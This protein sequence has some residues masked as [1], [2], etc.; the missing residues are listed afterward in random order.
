MTRLGVKI[1]LM[2][3]EKGWDEV[4]DVGRGGWNYSV[5]KLVEVWEHKVGVVLRAKAITPGPGLSLGHELAG[6]SREV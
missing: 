2:E 1:D 3:G 6:Q 5:S 4:M